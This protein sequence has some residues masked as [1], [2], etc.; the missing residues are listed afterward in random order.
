MHIAVIYGNCIMLTDTHNFISLP[1]HNTLDCETWRY[2]YRKTSRV[3]MAHHKY[4]R[5]DH[6]F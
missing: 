4:D 2:H 5:D 1:E 3:I 6:V